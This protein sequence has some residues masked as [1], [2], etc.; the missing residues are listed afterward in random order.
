[1]TE[2]A[3]SLPLVEHVLYK[4]TTFNT[5]IKN[6]NEYCY[7]PILKNAHSSGVDFF[8]K[9]GFYK[10]RNI[11][12]KKYIVFLRDPLHRWHSGVTEWLLSNVEDPN[13]YIL[14]D[15]II[16]LIF[17]AGAVD[18]HSEMQINYLYGLPID[19]CIFFNTDDIYFDFKFKHFIFHNLNIEINET[20]FPK[21]NTTAQNKAKINIH[22]QLKNIMTD[23]LSLVK[24]LKMYY[25][26]DYEFMR[27][28]TFYEPNK[29]IWNR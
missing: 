13:T 29:K 4:K 16:K 11:D 19:K 22:T 1:M 15:L 8:A 10:S 23:R 2:Y 24:K 27:S 18:A 14:D 6:G 3:Y 9:N 20:M 7:V 25:L 26:P 28:I 17:D 21:L 5:M 12:G